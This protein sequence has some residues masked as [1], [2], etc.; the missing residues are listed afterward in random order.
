M[1]NWRILAVDDEPINLDIIVDILDAPEFRVHTVANAEAA[2]AMIESAPYDVVILDRMMPGLDGLGLLRR[3]KADPRHR[4]LPVVMQTAAAAPEQVREGIEAGAYYYLTKPYDPRAL[5]AIVRAALYVAAARGEVVVDTGDHRRALALARRGE[6]SFRTLDEAAALASFLASLCPEPSAA[7]MG[8]AE[9]MVNAIEHGNLDIG[10][11]EKSRLRL[12]NRWQAEVSRRLGDPRW[13]ER[14]AEVSFERD[15]AAI[16]FLIADQGE[17]FD[18]R[19]YLDIDPQR[20]CDPNGRGIA[21]AR[22]I[23]F[24]HL[25]YRDRGNVVVGRI[26]LDDQQ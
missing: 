7:R 15:A 21:L 16:T 17:G 1:K 4:N 14:V 3:I 12:S 13:W 24:S 20:A 10:Y 8:L 2:W 26:D 5:L 11:A 19:R 9:L 22:R 23:S 18:Y 6:F 25:E